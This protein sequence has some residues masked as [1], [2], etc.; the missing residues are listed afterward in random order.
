EARIH[1]VRYDLH[2]TAK[3]LVIW[4]SD[5]SVLRPWAEYFLGLLVALK[6]SSWGQPV[7][8]LGKVYP[9]GVPF[10]FPLVYLIKEPMA[11]H[12]LTV[13]GLLF[14]LSKIHLRIFRRAWLAEH[15]TGFAFLIVMGI[16]WAALIRSHMN[17]GVRHLL[18]VFPLTY[19]LVA[20]QVVL[21]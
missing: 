16:Y 18:P 7:F 1:R 12:L 19:I 9:E 17:I 8:I 14:A 3:D 21:F 5:K 6:A 11:M 10:Y 15:F 20:N 13:F 2:G 4:A